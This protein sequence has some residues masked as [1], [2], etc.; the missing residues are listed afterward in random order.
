MNLF[1]LTFA[2]LL[3][4][5]FLLNF[6]IL[7]INEKFIV[8]LAFLFFFGWISTSY[9]NI[10]SDGLSNARKAIL[11]SQLLPITNEYNLISERKKQVETMIKEL[12]FLQQ[13]KQNEKQLFPS[14]TFDEL[15]LIEKNLSTYQ[16]DFIAKTDS[17][18]LV[19]IKNLARKNIK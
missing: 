19:S 18:T 15:K 16:Q 9:S 1:T 14:I 2:L 6:N 4:L 10:L 11:Q 7:I 3:L 8:F 17:R 12:A 5:F 13:I